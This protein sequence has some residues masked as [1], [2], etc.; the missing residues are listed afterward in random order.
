M[1]TTC[2]TGNADEEYK[3]NVMTLN[4][5][6]ITSSPFEFYLTEYEPQLKRIGEFFK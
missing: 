6:G 4:Y 5:C 3:L 1:G 2:S